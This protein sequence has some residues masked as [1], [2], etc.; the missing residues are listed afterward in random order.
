M[1]VGLVWLLV[2]VLGWMVI[3]DCGGIIVCLVV[4]GFV[5][6]LGFVGVGL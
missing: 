3:G 6:W 4:V 5:V 2:V 1:C